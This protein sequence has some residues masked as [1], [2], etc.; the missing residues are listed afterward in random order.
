MVPTHLQAV[1][2]SVDD[3]LRSYDTARRCGRSSR[4]ARRSPQAVKA[5]SSSASARGSF[6]SAMARPRASVVSN[7]RPA[8]QLRKE[9]SFGLPYA[10]IR[11]AAP[12]TRTG[13]PSRTERWANL[14]TARRMLFNGYWRRPEETAAA[15]R[16]GW[17]ST[18]DLARR[19]DEGYLYVVDRKDDQIV[20]GGINVYPREV[21][22]VLLRHPAVAEA[23]VFGVPDERWGEAV[24]AAVVVRDGRRRTERG[25]D[26]RVLQPRAC[27][28]QAPEGD[29]LRA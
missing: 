5:R 11:G 8:D 26:Q 16:D 12:S 13:R 24:R 1:S 20:T 18:G 25:G 7:L 29:R 27:P 21:E 3:V 15:L 23:A 14:S 17:C 19:D 9:Q 10:T 2:G 28:L 6:T 22:E 4:M